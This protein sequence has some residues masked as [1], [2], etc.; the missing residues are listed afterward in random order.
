MPIRR[1]VFLAGLTLAF[2]QSGLGFAQE[3]GVDWAEIDKEYTEGV[4]P[5]LQRYCLKCHS[6][7]KRKGELDLE[8]F[9]LL[10]HVRADLKPWQKMIHQV[11]ND[12]MPPKKSP[13]LSAAEEK[14]LLAWVDSMLAG[15]ARERAGDP[16]R[17]ILRRLNNTEYNNTVRD[18]TGLDLDPTRQFPVDGAA[19]EGFANTGA[20]LVMSPS[21][22]N[23]YL[24][25]DREIA[26]HLVLTPAGIEF[27][28]GTTRPEWS[29]TLVNEVKEFYGRYVSTGGKVP[30]DDYLEATLSLRGGP[31][32]EEAVNAMA[33]ERRLNA[34]YLLAMW[35]VLT[36]KTA[37]PVIDRLQL[38]W[39]DS[40]PGELSALKS[41]IDGL[42]KSLWNINNVGHYKKWQ[43]EVDA[44]AEEVPLETPLKS[45]GGESESVVYLVAGAGGDGAGENWVLWDLPRLEG[46]RGKPIYL[47]DLR[48]VHRRLETET[49]SILEAL[50][51]YLKAAGEVH[52]KE[53]SRTEVASRHQLDKDRLVRFL[54]F[55]GVGGPVSPISIPSSRPGVRRPLLTSSVI[56]PIVP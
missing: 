50:P 36:S 15:E 48:V 40:K 51:G 5:L 44:V 1:C 16:G 7:Q 31:E 28:K 25:A 6:S 21:L 24:D 26:G 27:F 55:V 56:P 42:Q 18:L 10:A 52:R 34:R 32:S 37:S 20:S 38:V 30:L 47:R 43:E 53:G 2:I 9:K 4:L 3:S 45:G 19:G 41:T 33:A 12:E 49:A 46:G 17:V 22:V 14:L 54:G 11:V 29:Q 13:Q 35:K 8:R 39:R 23:K